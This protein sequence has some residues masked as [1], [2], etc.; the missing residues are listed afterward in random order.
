MTNPPREDFAYPEQLRHDIDCGRTGDK[1]AF[2]D[3]AVAPLGTDEE[4]AGTPVSGHAAAMARRIE[5]ARMDKLR[6]QDRSGRV[7]RRRIVLAVVAII[8]AFLA[9]ALL[10]R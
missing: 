5:T 7:G 3:P 10:L 4:A 8:G 2:P 6:Q 1:V 9:G